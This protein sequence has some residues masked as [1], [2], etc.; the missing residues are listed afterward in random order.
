MK[1]AIWGN[2]LTAWATAGALAQSGNDICLVSHSKIK[3]PATLMGSK[4][5]PRSAYRPTS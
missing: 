2:E 3:D 5:A 4:R 1:I